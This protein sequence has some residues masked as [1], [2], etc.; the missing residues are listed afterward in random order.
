MRVIALIVAA[1]RGTR[2]GGP[3]PKQW[4]PLGQMRV[5]DHAIAAFETHPLISGVAVVLHADD[6][7]E[8]NAFATRGI[9][10]TQGGAER[11]QSVHAGLRALPACDAVLIHDAARACVSHK[12]I[13]DVIAALADHTGAAPGVA[14]T[15]A[16]WTG[17]DGMVTGTQDRNG[18]FAAQ[19]PQGFHFDAIIAAH[20]SYEGAAADDVAVARAAGLNIAITQ[21]DPDNIKI[22]TPADFTRAA[23]VLE[24]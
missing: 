5:I 14:V 23:R 12:I 3:R 8:G 6:M 21:G 24:K 16:L 1:G 20:E 15:D 19:T 18:L 7:A 2:A 11:N 13:T 17:S 9:T 4:Q 10:I 22:T